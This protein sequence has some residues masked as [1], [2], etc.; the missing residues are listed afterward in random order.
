MSAHS[1]SDAFLG[2]IQHSLSYA[3]QPI[4]NVHTGVAYGYE[5][6]LRGHQKLGLPSIQ[7]LFDIAWDMGILH[8]LD[9]ILRTIALQNFAKL[10]VGRGKRLF[11]NID[12]RCFESPDYYPD[13]THQLLTDNGLAQDQLCLE[14]SESYDNASAPY[15]RETLERCRNQNFRLALDD[16]G[17]GYSELRMLYEYQP[18]YLKIDRFFVDGISSDPKKRMMVASL[19][20][21]AHGLGISVIAEGIERIDDFLACKDVGCDLVQ[22]YLIDRPTTELTA[23]RSHYVVVNEIN[24]SDRRRK[25]Q[26]LTRVG[27]MVSDI[28]P[29]RDTDGTDA[30]LDVFKS[31]T[32]N[33]GFFPVVDASNEPRGLV[34]ESDLKGYL[35]NQ[36]GH[37]LLSNKAFGNPIS[38]FVAKCPV[39]GVEQSLE[40][41]LS[42]YAIGEIPEGIIITENF[43]YRGFLTTQSLLHLLN[44]RRLAQAQD[45]NPLTRLPGNHSVTDYIAAALDDDSSDHWGF[46]YFDFNNFKPFND[47]YGFRQGDRAIMLFSDLMKR[48]LTGPDTFLGHVG[49][50][51][52]FAGFR[53]PDLDIISS[54][55]QK[56]LTDFKDDVESFYEI[57]DRERGYIDGR[58]REGNNQQFQLLDCCAALLCLSDGQGPEMAEEL[59]HNLARLK[60]QAKLASNKFVVDHFPDQALKSRFHTV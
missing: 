53:N 48:T 36:Y 60:K 17:R 35:Y 12:G 33:L 30:V 24:L 25:K 58:D 56:L 50:D 39:A 46:V 47:Y 54:Q 8:S 20:N 29:I 28:A 43:K 13:K 18:D 19:V 23:I 45:Q 21:M 5:A 26:G 32:S 2:S 15:I 4:V 59:T 40:E 38:R 42:I 10:E 3:F 44:E 1:E 51:D 37:A 57:E 27:D 16:Y 52:F 11:F 34:R 9:I 14:L 6:L 41:I 49:G 22:G 55:I 7:S 31:D